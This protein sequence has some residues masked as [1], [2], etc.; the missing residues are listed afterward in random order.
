MWAEIYVEFRPWPGLAGGK[1]ESHQFA[2]E[3]TEGGCGLQI[4]GDFFVSG[5]DDLFPARTAPDERADVICQISQQREYPNVVGLIEGRGLRH[6]AETDLPSQ[7]SVPCGLALR[8]EA[9]EAGDQLQL[10]TDAVRPSFA[11]TDG[12][13]GP[14]RGGEDRR[15][16]LFLHK[17][18]GS[19]WFPSFFEG[20]KFSGGLEIPSAAGDHGGVARPV[21][22]PRAGAMECLVQRALSSRKKLAKLDARETFGRPAE[23]LICGGICLR[24]D[25]LW[26]ESQDGLRTVLKNALLLEVTL[27]EGADLGLIADDRKDLIVSAG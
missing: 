17:H 4:E 13:T 20:Q 2:D 25:S 7:K 19:V 27:S 15:R 18:K 21:S 23:K 8:F 5:D 16:F 9:E 14:D 22:D 10:V 12:V 6:R 26:V 11:P 3:E 24:D 1:H